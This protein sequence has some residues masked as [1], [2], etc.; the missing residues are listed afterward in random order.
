MCA[1][2]GV[3]N[4]SFSENFTYVPAGIYLLKVN[5]KNTRARCEICSKLTKRHV[6]VSLSLTWTYF[7]PC[8][9][10][11]IVNFEQVNADWGTKSMIPY[12]IHSPLAKFTFTQTSTRKSQHLSCMIASLHNLVTSSKFCFQ[13]F[14]VIFS[15]DLYLA[16]IGDKRQKN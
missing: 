16:K 12:Y 13:L 9:I 6:L 14:S 5:N 1:Y 10:A 7:T 4:N 8:S 11:F 3:R 2:R 15:L